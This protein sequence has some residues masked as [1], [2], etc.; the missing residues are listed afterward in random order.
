MSGKGQNNS[1]GFHVSGSAKVTVTNSAITAA[2]DSTAIVNAAPVEADLVRRTLELA[3]VL[4][5]STDPATAQVAAD[6]HQEAASP[7][8]HWER[9][10][11]FLTRAGQGVVATT[12]LA[13]DIQALESSIRALL[14]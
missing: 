10:L 11:H 8:P 7:A 14:P 9:V 3:A 5:Q 2:K 12:A 1:G 13:T 6:L 4:R